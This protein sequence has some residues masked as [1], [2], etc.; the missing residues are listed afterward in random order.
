MFWLNGLEPAI[1]E[2]PDN[3][4]KHPSEDHS[5]AFRDTRFAYPLR[6]DVP[7]LR[8]LNMTVRPDLT[9]LHTLYLELA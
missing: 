5:I 4:D 9:S 1:N 2:T 3:H 6:P 7:V 8:G